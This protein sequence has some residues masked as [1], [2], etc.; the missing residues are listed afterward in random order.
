MLFSPS[1]LFLP[2]F[3]AQD[4]VLPALRSSAWCLNRLQYLGAAV[5]KKKSGLALSALGWSL[6]IANSIFRGIFGHLGFQILGTLYM[7]RHMQM[8]FFKGLWLGKKLAVF[9]WELQ[10]DNK[11]LAFQISNYCCEEQAQ[12]LLSKILVRHFF[13]FSFVSVFIPPNRGKICFPSI[14]FPEVTK[15]SHLKHKK[16]IIISLRQSQSMGIFIANT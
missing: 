12:E 6:P 8:R 13:L 15:S 5:A 7:L 11:D 3:G 9:S 14:L 2:A 16:I 4:G 10:K 1:S